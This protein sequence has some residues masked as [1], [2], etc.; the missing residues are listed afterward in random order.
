MATCKMPLGCSPWGE[1]CAQVGTP[2][3]GF[4]AVAECKALRAQLV[5]H[6][7]AGCGSG[8][9]EGVTLVTKV[10]PHDYGDYFEVNVVFE[11]DSKAAVDAA[12]WLEANLPEEWD[13]EAQEALRE[14]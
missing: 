9:P 14:A 3:Y 13:E 1:D 11:D 10:N 8:L 2:G 5:R 7:Q 6:Y 4:R 12:F